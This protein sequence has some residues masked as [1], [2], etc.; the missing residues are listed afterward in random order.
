[1]SLLPVFYGKAAAVHPGDEIFGSELF[2]YRSVRQGDWKI[3]WDQAAPEEQRRWQL[4]N[5]ARDFSEQHDLS[6]A[7]PDMYARMQQ[8]WGSYEKENGVIY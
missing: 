8:A 7:N 1:M 3:V 4:F 2:G 6:A 5:V